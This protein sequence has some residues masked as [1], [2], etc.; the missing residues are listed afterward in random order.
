MSDLTKC[1]SC[2]AITSGNPVATV[3]RPNDLDS[4][5]NIRCFHHRD[6]WCPCRI[7]GIRRKSWS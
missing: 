7:S 2:G 6:V 1:K 5:A 3:V 4:L